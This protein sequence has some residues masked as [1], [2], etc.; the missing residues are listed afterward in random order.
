M[1]Q[2]P[3]PGPSGEGA[4]YGASTRAVHAGLPDFEQGTP[5]LGGPVFAA[6]FHLRGAKDAHEF[7]Y[8][9]DANPTWSALETALGGLEGGTSLVFASGMAAVTAT[10]FSVLAPGDKLVAVHDGYP[11]V[12]AVATERLEPAGIAVQFVSTDTEEI[13]AAVDGARLV[14][15]ETPSNP[16]LDVCDIAAISAAAHKAGALVAVDN[17][18]ATPLGQ[19]P[20]ALGADISMMSGTKTLCG[21]SDV[22]LGV[23]SVRDDA[24]VEALKRWRSQSGSI[25]GAFEAWLAHR[26]LA[27]LALRLERSSAGALA[28]AG[29]LRERGIETFHPSDHAASAQMLHH[30]CLVSFTLESEARAQALLARC[31]LVA[32][33]TSFGGVHATAER[34]ERWG[35]DDVPPGFIRYSAGIEDPADLVADL[36]QALA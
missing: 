34:R 12:R 1:T 10:L 30:G 5:L 13:C 3:E 14:W 33:A 24:L 11:G 25:V 17:T 27:T 23:V 35:T 32:E 8:G 28:V 20:L 6:P 9:R 15:I 16:K 18:L 29:A 7:G 26:S 21:H 22:L 2:Y 31:R 4:P 19:Q 36:L